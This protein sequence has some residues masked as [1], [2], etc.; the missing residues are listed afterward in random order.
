MSGTP[1]V[2]DGSDR[3]DA[4]GQPSNGSGG[5]YIGIRD[6][7]PDLAGVP[8]PGIPL[9]L[10]GWAPDSPEAPQP[11]QEPP[12]KR[13]RH[14][15]VPA[16]HLDAVPD[17]EQPGLPEGHNEEQLRPDP[18]DV[19]KLAFQGKRF[20]LTY[21]GHIDAQKIQ[22]LVFQAFRRPQ[23]LI[24]VWWET[25]D[26]KHDY[27]HTHVL[28]DLL[29]AVR[30]KKS[31]QRD[32]RKPAN[33]L[34]IDGVHFD[35]KPINTKRHWRN[36][37]DYDDKGNATLQD[38]IQ[39]DTLPREVKGSGDRSDIK[40]ARELIESSNRWRDVLRLDNK[41]ITRHLDWARQ[42]FDTRAPEPFRIEVFRPWQE[43]ILDMLKT[44]PN[45][46]DVIWVE[47]PEGGAGKSK[48]TKHLV[49]ND[50]ALLYKGGKFKDFRYRV[51]RP[52]VVIF[53]L[54]RAIGT[55]AAPYALIEET[56]DGLVVSDKY[57]PTTKIFKHPHVV[58][59]SN[60]PPQLDQ[61]SL[62]RWKYYK[63]SMEDGVRIL[64]PQPVG[65]GRQGAFN[66]ALP[67]LRLQE[68]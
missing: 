64:V 52:R 46:R 48:L 35:F 61:L 37:Q 32:G 11:F 7:T 62:N 29:K 56:K 43:Q 49:V 68:Y 13:R 38:H 66:P 23:A 28:V 47:D 10:Q 22:T 60:H 31:K 36:A 51:E 15:A 2:N 33:F 67:V 63:M 16:V 55:E 44:E 4:A 17:G 30:Y 6:G 21:P 45:D 9:A 40:E 20:M 34:D 25:S 65:V 27:D 3:S 58:V 24:R 1:T 19:N 39:L 8:V 41:F 59:F 12:Q 42:V 5:D 50:N 18:Q 54:V 14:G 53:D 57:R 26:S